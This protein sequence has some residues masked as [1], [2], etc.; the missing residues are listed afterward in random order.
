MWRNQNDW[1]G[2]R[3]E[4]DFVY[5]WHGLHISILTFIQSINQSNIPS[6]LPSFVRS[7]V[8]S[9]HPAAIAIVSSNVPFPTGHPSIHLIAPLER[10]RSSA[11][12]I[13]YI[14]SLY[15]SMRWLD[16][17]HQDKKRHWTICTDVMRRSCN[18]GE[19]VRTYVSQCGRRAQWFLS[20]QSLIIIMALFFI[21][22]CPCPDTDGRWCRCSATCTCIYIYIH[23][24]IHVYVSTGESVKGGLCGVWSMYFCFRRVGGAERGRWVGQR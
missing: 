9:F 15:F 4:Y 21:I 5:S 13:V 7:F 2:E 1:R 18:N 23:T 24:Y 16:G 17:S 11:Q 20:K 3:F 14:H 8:R 19:Y 6:F 12:L 22:Y 10:R